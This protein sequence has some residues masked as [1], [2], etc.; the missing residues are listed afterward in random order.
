MTETICFP[1]FEAHFVNQFS[2]PDGC[3]P[4]QRV[5]RLGLSRSHDWF[6]QSRRAAVRGRRGPDHREPDRPRAA[7]LQRHDRRHAGRAWPA[8]RTDRPERDRRRRAGRPLLDGSELRRRLLDLALRRLPRNGS[9]SDRRSDDGPGRDEL[10]RHERLQRDDLLLQGVRRQQWKWGGREVERSERDPGRSHCTGSSTGRAR[11]LQSRRRNALRRGQ[12]DERNRRRLRD[13]TGGRFERTRLHVRDHVHCV[14]Q[15]H[16]VRGGRESYATISTMPGDGNA[17]RLYVRLQTPGSG[18]VDGYMLLLS[19]AAG[20]DSVVIYRVTNGSLAAIFTA[21]QD[22]ATGDR[23]LFRARAGVLEAWR[24]NGS[25]WSR[26]GHVSDE[27]YST[28]GYAGVGLRGTS[29]RL[30]D[31]GART[32]GGATAPGAPQGLQASA[33]NSQVALSW[34][35]PASDGGSQVTSYRLYRSTSSGTEA[36]LRRRRSR[37]RPIRIRA[38]PTARP[39]STRCLRPTRS[40]TARSRMRRVLHPPIWLHQSIRSRRWTPSTVPTR[41][42][43]PIPGSGRTPSTEPSRTV[44]TSPRTNWPAASPRLAPPGATTPSSGRIQR[45]GRA[46]P[47]FPA[48]ER[49]P[50]LLTSSVSRDVGLRR[51]HAALQSSQRCRSGHAVPDHEQQS[52]HATQVGQELG[53]G[54][55][56]LLRAEGTSLEVWRKAA[57]M[58][59]TRR[60]P[61]LHLHRGRSCGHRLARY[62]GPPR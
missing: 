16:P 28:A 40:A 52:D 54:D 31:F 9:E 27:T 39:T 46:S 13:W 37:R 19:Q 14:A 12:L 29:G 55:T 36:L 4:L 41:T 3:R 51:L 56:L 61:G 8:R 6:Q 58:V 34:N 26:I 17:V 30:D 23:L 44:S 49:N 20:P 18:A 2:V 47:R 50:P 59:A 57:H 5:G 7:A 11:L 48:R 43:S 38:S 45:R 33:G 10:H 24:H 32:I 35:A 60:R 15:Q 1:G 22:F 42:R 21:N 25:S 62:R 53:V